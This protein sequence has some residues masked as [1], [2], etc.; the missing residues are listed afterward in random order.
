[1]SLATTN[2]LRR[3]G[4]FAF[5][6]G[7]SFLVGTS[8]LLMPQQSAAAMARLA[9]GLQQDLGDMTTSSEASGK[10]MWVTSTMTA[11]NSAKS[12]GSMEPQV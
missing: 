4:A 8:S 11:P 5:L 12:A 7:A 2:R 1:M 9:P 3:I 6:A 10:G